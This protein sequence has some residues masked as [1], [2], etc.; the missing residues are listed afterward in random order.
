MLVYILF[1]YNYKQIIH[2]R[3]HN[4]YFVTNLDLKSDWIKLKEKSDWFLCLSSFSF[5]PFFGP[6]LLFCTFMLSFLSFF[7]AFCLLWNTGYIHLFGEPFKHKSSTL[8]CDWLSYCTHLQPLLMTRLQESQ[9]LVTLHKLP[10]H[11]VGMVYKVVKVVCG[12][13]QPVTETSQIHGSTTKH[14]VPFPI[15]N[16]H[17]HACMHTLFYAVFIFCFGGR[18]SHKTKNSW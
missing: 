3:Y 14:P 2:S 15:K 1:A 13:G 18:T 8:Y 5:L 16:T 10:L 12:S 11:A 17:A 4:L 7:T 6:I 9:E